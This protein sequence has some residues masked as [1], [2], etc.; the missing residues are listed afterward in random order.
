M[1][2]REAKTSVP[3]S[4]RTEG[5]LRV[6]AVGTLRAQLLQQYCCTRV[7]VHLAAG[8]APLRHYLCLCQAPQLVSTDWRK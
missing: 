7:Q 1:D 2:P 5:L 4:A 8:G 3:W 6:E